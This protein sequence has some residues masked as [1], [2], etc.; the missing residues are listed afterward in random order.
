MTKL[1]EIVS[2][3]ADGKPFSDEIPT[4]PHEI[5]RL[6]DAV[7]RMSTCQGDLIGMANSVAS[8]KLDFVPKARSEEDQLATAFRKMLDAQR[9]LLEQLAHS[10][11]EVEESSRQLL[12][13][14]EQSGV[15]TQQI[16]S[17]ITHVAQS[18][19][20]Q[21]DLIVRAKELVEGQMKASDM[22]SESALRMDKAVAEIEQLLANR[23]TP[24]VNQVKE[25][26]I[27]SGAAAAQASSAA[28]QGAVTVENTITRLRSMAASMEEVAARVNEMGAHSREID[29][30]VQTIDDIAERTNLLA[31][32]A[33]IEAARAGTH[34]QGFAVVA[35]EVRKLAERSAR[36]AQEIGELIKT[37]QQ[38][39][40]KAISAMEASNQEIAQGLTMA[41]ETQRGL[42]EIQAAV[43][44]VTA[45]MDSLAEAVTDMSEGNQA[46][47]TVMQ[48]VAATVED[49]SACAEN[50]MTNG[51]EVLHTI[52]ELAAIAEEN[53][54][55]AEQVS[56]STAEM[57]AQIEESA[58]SA[59]M[60]LE[61]AQEL[62]QTLGH[63]TWEG[64]RSALLMETEHRLLD[65]FGPPPAS[66]QNGHVPP[67]TVGAGP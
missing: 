20:A 30:I 44:Q 63:F 16:A 62:R 48:D 60:L 13:A 31:L 33:A 46:V 8:G 64:E 23:L 18:A 57:S 55:A 35:D 28:Q 42:D 24:A 66:R 17:S 37:V 22:I 9:A 10:A 67:Q 27:S 26:A 45:H 38:T 3:L 58:A 32:N 4:G 51:E 1:T 54:A 59:N 65:A 25:K 11:R 53:S 7:T 12:T 15:A 50:L 21:T 39:A 29:A 36:S 61:M 47:L 43:T 14:S 41:D 5:G 49:N 56:A 19:G 34:G 52:Q 2:A 6:A 40:Q